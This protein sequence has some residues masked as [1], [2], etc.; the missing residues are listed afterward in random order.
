MLWRVRGCSFGQ[1]MGPKQAH[2]YKHASYFS[3]RVVST[4]DPSLRLSAQLDR[5]PASA[6]LPVQP[7]KFHHA[8]DQVYGHEALSSQGSACLNTASALFIYD[9][10]ARLVAST[11]AKQRGGEQS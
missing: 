3:V 8:K 4:C 1:H 5:H 7:G 2:S 11:S 6:A 10:D 9:R